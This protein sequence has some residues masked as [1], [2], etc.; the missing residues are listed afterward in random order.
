MAHVAGQS[1]Y[2]TTLFPEALDEVIAADNE[3]LVV[4]AY[5][6]ALDLA[7]LGFS[8]VEAAATG[9][10]PYDPRDLAKLYLYGYLNRI[11]SSRG[12]SVKPAAT[13]KCFG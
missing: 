11:R 10:P 4:D 8:N 5:V 6:D 1:R 13:W 12:L 3:V 9:R 2:Q 7:E